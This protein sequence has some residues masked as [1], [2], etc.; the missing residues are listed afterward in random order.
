MMVAVGGGEEV[1]GYGLAVGL[2]VGADR[3]G[4]S[5]SLGKGSAWTAGGS[6]GAKGGWGGGMDPEVAG[7]ASGERLSLLVGLPDFV[8]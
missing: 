6:M 4:R 5:G 1:E 2:R 3:C 7:G 8:V